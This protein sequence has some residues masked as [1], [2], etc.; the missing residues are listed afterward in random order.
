METFHIVPESRHN[1]LV[2]AAYRHRGYDADESAEGASVCADASRHGIRTHNGLKALHLD[3]FLGSGSQGCIPGAKI[4]EKPSRFPAIK[5]WN[6]NRKLG[7]STALRSMNE[8]IRLA[9]GPNPKRHHGGTGDDVFLFRRRVQ[10]FRRIASILR[11]ER[12]A[13]AARP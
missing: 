12:M 10:R 8:A 9:D 1:T 7:Q 3:H 6:A 11:R 13:T 4:E 2:A 5:I